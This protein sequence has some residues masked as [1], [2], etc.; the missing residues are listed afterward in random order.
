MTSEVVKN[1]VLR[2][3]ASGVDILI[4]GQLDYRPIVKGKGIELIATGPVEVHDHKRGV[5]I[6]LGNS[7]IRIVGIP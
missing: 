3:E 1:L 4:V 5:A 2:I 7:E 6:D